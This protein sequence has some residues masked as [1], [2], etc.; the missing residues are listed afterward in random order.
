MTELEFQG[1]TKVSLYRWRNVYCKD[2]SIYTCLVVTMIQRTHVIRTAPSIKI[3]NITV[4]CIIG[5]L[6]DLMIIKGT[7]IFVTREFII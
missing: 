5:N 2:W 6:N 4:F 1:W 3:Y 7:D